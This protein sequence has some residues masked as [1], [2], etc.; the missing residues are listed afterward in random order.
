MQIFVFRW[1]FGINES[2][3]IEDI[4]GSGVA[5][6]DLMPFPSELLS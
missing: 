4:M 6:N 1:R 3:S 2:K 5:H